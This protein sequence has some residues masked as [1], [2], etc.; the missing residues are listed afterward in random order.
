MKLR[1]EN[2]LSWGILEAIESIPTAGKLGGIQCNPIN[3]YSET[4]SQC[5]K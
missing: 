4:K 1:K 3:V 2:I 5:I